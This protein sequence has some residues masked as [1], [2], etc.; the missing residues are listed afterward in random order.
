MKNTL[1]NY[2]IGS[3]LLSLSL[4]LAMPVLAQTTLKGDAQIEAERFG[5]KVANASAVISGKTFNRSS[6]FSPTN[7]EYCVPEGT[8]SGRYINNFFTTG[9]SYNISNMGSGFSP[10][11]YGDFYD[12]HTLAQAQGGEVEFEVDIEGGISGFRIWVDW[13]Q[14]GV[15]ETGEIAYTSSEYGNSQNGTITVPVDALRGD[16]RMRIVSHWLSPTGDVDPC[17]TEFN[18]GEFED[19]KFT[20][21]EAIGGDDFVCDDQ[22]NVSNGIEGGSFLGGTTNQRMAVDIVVGDEGFTAYGSNINI[23]LATGQTP[24]DLS[25][26]FIF[27]E[28]DAGTPGNEVH[29][30]AGIVIGAD[31]IGENFG[32]DVYAFE[33]I[34]EDAA[35]FNA[36]TTYWMEVESNG[37]AWETTTVDVFGSN[38]AFLN[39]NTGGD[40]A[41]NPTGDAVYSLICEEVTIGYCEPVLDCT[42][43]DLITN[44]TFQ[45]ID[46]TT[47]CSPNGYGDYTPLVATVQ[48]NGTYPISVTVGGGWTSESVSVWI[49]FDN[50]ETFDEDEFFYIGTGSSEVL[51]GEIEIPAG[52]A[53]GEYRMR[54]RVAAAVQGSATWDM[55]CDDDEQR[56]GETE[57]Y[58]VE[59]NGELGLE[60]QPS[61]TFSYYPNPTNGIVNINASKDIS[62]I[63]VVNILGQQVLEMN[64]LE[65]GQVDIS[66]LSA[67]TY[68]FRATFEDGSVET[69]KVLKK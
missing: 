16:T 36:N 46:N 20:V 1:P 19:Y 18:Y 7:N 67:G 69:F 44:V 64:R 8:N 23:F 48:S 22:F 39:D 52:L 49:D 6:T 59:V 13:N 54:V 30:S 25:F 62:S 10:N 28:D 60:D 43:G 65:N 42:D 57:D 29:T 21:E 47:A 50:S 27:Y 58:T 31:F 9:G 24:D 63:V 17:E 53:D 68:M 5:Q 45:E 3:W 4:F 11:G 61:A 12:T 33:V 40:W 38:L 51:T 32:Y 41:I 55:A 34:F 66:T 14:N 15:F 2:F 35:D 26:D 37:E 56:Y